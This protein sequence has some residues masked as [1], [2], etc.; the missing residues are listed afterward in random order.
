MKEIKHLTRLS[1][2]TIDEIL[3]ILQVANRLANGETTCSL[4]GGVV[5]NLFFEPSTR[6]QYSF[7]MAEQKLGLNT[8]DFSAQTSSVQK[9]ETLY[10]TVKTFEA[11]G[12]DAVVIR[13]PQNNYFD[14]LIGK[15]DIPILNGGDGSGNHPTQSLLDLLTIYQEYGRFEGLKIAI[16]GDIA[17]SRVAHTNI[18]VMTRLGMD[19]H[20]VAPA[21][22]QE[23]GYDWE[24]LDKVLEDM[25]IV[26]LLRV[27]HERHDGTMVLTKD[28]YHQKYG[29]T[30]EREKR[31]KEGA[32]IMHPAPFNRGV[33]I[34]DEVVECNRSRIFKQMSNGVF[35]RM[36]CLHR[37][38]KN[39]KH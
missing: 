6:T 20:L 9:G 28:E 33:E 14:E 37:S 2:L 16:V 22:F 26:M 32:I 5:A 35:I 30:V 7:L 13:H 11:I 29:L 38:L 21:Q 18:E 10:D 15:I 17:H 8:M 39:K 34:A 25:D 24:E 23:P 27:Q 3:E 4:S 19:V 12:V 31:M 36:A 1:D